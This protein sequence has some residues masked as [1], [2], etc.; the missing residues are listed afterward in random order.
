MAVDLQSR[1]REQEQEGEQDLR[2]TSNATVVNG[3]KL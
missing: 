3:E 2:L 1:Q